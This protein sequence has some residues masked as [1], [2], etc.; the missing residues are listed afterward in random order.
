MNFFKQKLILP[1]KLQLT[2]GTGAHELAL[3]CAVGVAFGAFPLLGTTT[4]LCVFFGAILKLNH[5]ILQIINYLMSPL[6]LVLIPIWLKLGALITGTPTIEISPLKIVA[7]FK[8]SLPAFFE[9]YGLAG[10]HAVLAWAILI[11][12]IAG[13]IYFVTY[14]IFLHWTADNKNGF[15]R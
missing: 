15:K 13:T 12:W 11:P 14:R 4:L 10:F 3:T 8:K 9:N 6:Q 5:P 7:E 1:L 2:Q